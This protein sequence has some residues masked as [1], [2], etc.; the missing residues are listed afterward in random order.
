MASQNAAASRRVNLRRPDIMKAVEA[1]T[2][3]HYR[4]RLIDHL[5]AHGGV[6]SAGDLR[7]CL[8]K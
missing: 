2:A 1:L 4:S 7:V 8:A 3:S 5:R 6:V